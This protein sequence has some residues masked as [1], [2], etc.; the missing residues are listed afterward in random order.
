MGLLKIGAAS[1]SCLRACFSLEP[2][3]AIMK[4][5]GY[6]S[7][8]TRLLEGGLRPLAIPQFGGC[9]KTQPDNPTTG[10]RRARA[11]RAS[12]PETLSARSRTAR[13]PARRKTADLF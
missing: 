7:S 13:P 12:R 11:S 5:P 1:R 6:L 8:D 3:P 2:A 4:A 10:A 9:R